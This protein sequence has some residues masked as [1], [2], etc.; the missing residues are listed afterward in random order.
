MSIVW[1]VYSY[2]KQTA[3]QNNCKKKKILNRIQYPIIPV[4]EYYNQ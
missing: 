3:S 2:I 4:N 1:N